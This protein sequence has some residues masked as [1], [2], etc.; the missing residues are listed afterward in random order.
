MIE[1]IKNTAYDIAEDYLLTNTDMNDAL[2]EL[3]RNG[4]IENLSVLKRICETANQN[5]YLSL[6]QNE[7]TDKT[8]IKFDLADYDSL[9]KEIKKGEN[10]MERY[11]TPP[12]DFRQL[13]TLAVG[14]APE[15]IPSLPEGGEKRAELQKVSRYKDTFEAFVS[16]VE[17][18]YHHEMMNTE[19]SF[20]QMEKEAKIMVANGE[21]LGDIAKIA[22]RHVRDQGFDFMKVAAAYNVI[23]KNLE[24]NNFKIKTG[25]TKMS[26]LR[27]NANAPTLKPVDEFIQSIEKAAALNEMLT[28][29]GNTLSAIK[30][31]VIKEAKAK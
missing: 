20:Q 10:D 3:Y 5:V 13:L 8:N 7:D 2:L 28:N 6:Y 4:D 9:K 29:L 19:R 11:Q 22:S 16:D 14:T 1:A 30:N 26:S 31:F 21:S 23:Q 25:F 27:I 15:D 17:S 12:T 24:Q 18:L